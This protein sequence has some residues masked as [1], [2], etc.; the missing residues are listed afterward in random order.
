MISLPED[1]ALVALDMAER[2]AGPV[3]PEEAS[4]AIRQAQYLVPLLHEAFA[5][6]GLDPEEM[7][8]PEIPLMKVTR[9][10]LPDE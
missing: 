10:A 2:L 7:D 3:S 8:L 9:T 6:A 4:F 5:E 1:I